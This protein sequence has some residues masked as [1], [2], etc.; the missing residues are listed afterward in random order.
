MFLCD[1]LIADRHSHT[2]AF[3]D[4]FSGKE[5]VEYLLLNMLRNTDTIISDRNLHPL[6]IFDDTGVDR[7]LVI[8]SRS[9][10]ILC[11]FVKNQGLSARVRALGMLVK[12]KKER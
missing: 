4:R 5:G 11:E 7:N 9:L 10:V 12:I 1:D 6:P 3:S 8:T 2:R